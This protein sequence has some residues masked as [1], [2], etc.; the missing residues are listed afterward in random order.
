MSS[1]LLREIACSTYTIYYKI[2]GKSICGFRIFQYLNFSRFRIFNSLTNRINWYYE[3][4]CQNCS[5]SKCKEKLPNTVFLQT[6]CSSETLRLSLT[7][8]LIAH[9]T[10][11]GY[12]TEI[13]EPMGSQIT[14]CTIAKY[15]LHFTHYLIIIH[16]VFEGEGVVSPVRTFTFTFTISAP[17]F[18]MDPV[19][20]LMLMIN[21]IFSFSHDQSTSLLLNKCISQYAPLRRDITSHP[22]FSKLP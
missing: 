16:Y 8:L 4:F 1:K 21:V 22:S 7:F 20:V 10:R 13:L 6:K 9:P 19:P 17:A 18:Y 14:F 5:F 3:Q 12:K 15:S 11:R 2:S